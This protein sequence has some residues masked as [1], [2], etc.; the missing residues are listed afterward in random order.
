MAEYVIKPKR[1][2]GLHL[3]EIWQFRELFLA[4]TVRDMKV[5]YKQT[6]IGVLWAVFQPFI[7]MVVFT[8]FFGRIAQIST[9]GVPYPIFVYSGLLFWNYF[10]NALSAASGSMVANQAII[11]KIYFP[12]IIL[13]TASV[14][15]FLLD[16]FFSS[17]IFAGLL[18]YYHVTPSIT[19]LF[20]LVP[21]L[22]ITTLTLLGIGLFFSAVNVKYRDVRYVLPFFIQLLLFVTPVIYPATILGEYKWLL[23]LNPMSGVIDVF[24]STFLSLGSISWPL[25]GS[26][27]LVSTIFF[28]IGLAYFQKTERYFADLI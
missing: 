14:V 26:S 21:M 19:G 10:S 20:L 1:P 18:I 9:N 2:I 5:R 3:K 12:R 28:L 17:I 27:I 4:L 15:V 16:F 6:A 23:Y 13:P 8:I 11:Q 25:F 22:L 7:L 24:R